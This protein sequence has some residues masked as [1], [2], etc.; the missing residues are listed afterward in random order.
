M[1]AALL[2]TFNYLKICPL[3]SLSRRNR[4]RAQHVAAA[5]LLESVLLLLALLFGS[6]RMPENKLETEIRLSK[7]PAGAA[8]DPTSIH[9]RSVVI[10]MHADTV[11]FMLDEGVDINEK[12]ANLHLDA[13]R[14]KE[15]GLDAQFFAIWVEPQYFGTGGERAVK[16]ADE[17]IAL[18]R[19]LAEKHPETWALATSAAEIRRSAAEGKLA[20]LMGLEGGYA[21]DEKLENVQRYYRMGVRYMSPAWSVSTSWAGSSGDAEGQTRGLNDF[22]RAVVREMNR[23]GMIIDVS[24]V[25]DKTFWDIIEASTKPVIATHSNAR[26]LT[27]VPRNLTDEQIRA[28]AAKGGVVCVVFY[29]AFVEA[30]WDEQKRRVDAEIAPLVE[31]ASRGVTSG[32]GSLE[33]IARDRVREREYLSRMPL[34]SIARV[35]DHI[36]Y[37]VSLVGVDH[38][39]LGSDFDGIQAVPRDLASVADFPN[40]TTELTRRGYTE[41]GIEKILGGN[42]L[43]VMEEA[44]GQ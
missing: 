5:L 38:V 19:A 29:P 9:R 44:D 40:L 32:P 25:S 17:Q 4:C 33:R 30:G 20:A 39:G 35:V 11:Q 28:L 12:A 34:V 41:S 10:D 37:I 18:V 23:L 21:I 27:N 2:T 7:T 43:R 14:M 22:G 8:L 42:V 13:L 26:A 24:H 31:A 16:R 15:G 3:F 1:S 6:C 36:D